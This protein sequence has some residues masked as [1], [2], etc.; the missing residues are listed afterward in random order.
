[1]QRGEDTSMVTVN[2]HPRSTNSP[3]W[4][5]LGVDRSGAGG[6]CQFPLGPG[7]L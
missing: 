4:L 6:L 3:S 2:G 7:L 5:A 1:M